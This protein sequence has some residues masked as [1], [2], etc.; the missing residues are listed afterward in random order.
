MQLMTS[1]ACVSSN[2]YEWKIP[3]K[4]LMEIKGAPFVCLKPQV[5]GSLRMILDGCEWAVPLLSQYKNDAGKTSNITLSNCTGYKE[6]MKRRNEAQRD[7]LQPVEIQATRR[8]R[9]ATLASI[10]NT[11]SAEA[12]PA[13]AAGKR[14]RAPPLAKAA[15]T[16]ADNGES[17]FITVDVGG[18]NVDMGCP[19]RADSALVVRCDEAML[20]AVFAFIRDRLEW[21]ELVTRPRGTAEDDTVD[22]ASEAEVIDY[23]SN[24]S[25]TDN[26]YMRAD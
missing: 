22:R 15:A 25:T 7:A 23:A 13:R 9:A 26:V 14:T 16:A 6:L 17:D 11:S 21:D 5:Y 2:G 18:V 4:C 3:Q 8:A 1:Y 20:N 12:A 24:G 10:F 19:M